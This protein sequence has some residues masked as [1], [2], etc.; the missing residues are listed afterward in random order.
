MGWPLTRRLSSE[1]NDATIGP[2]SSGWPES[3]TLEA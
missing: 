1:S 3:N 2:V